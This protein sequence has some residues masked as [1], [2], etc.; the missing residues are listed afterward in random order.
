MEA[1]RAKAFTWFVAAG[2]MATSAAALMAVAFVP[3]KTYLDV[4]S[5]K[6]EQA[7]MR[8][9]QADMHAELRNINATLEKIANSRRGWF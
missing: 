7:Q 3:V 6:S 9:E 2:Q 8:I 1:Y 5:I 4:E